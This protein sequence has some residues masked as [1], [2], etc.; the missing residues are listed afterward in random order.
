[1]KL[2]KISEFIKNP[3]IY[4]F[5]IVGLI[6]AVILLF[7]TRVFT[8]FAGI[9]YVYSTVIAFE[10]GTVWGFFVNDKWTFSNIKKS[11]LYFRFIKYNI[12]SLF[13]LGIIQVIMITFTTQIGINYTYSQ[14]IGI[15]VAFFFNFLANKKI[16]FK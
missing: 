13:A 6:G 1:M 15:I 7:F 8:E 9:F 10:I 3:E 12:F 11:K 16:S 4:K 14:T 5:F 2:K